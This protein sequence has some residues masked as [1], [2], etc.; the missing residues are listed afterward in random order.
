ML[1]KDAFVKGVFTPM[2]I[3]GERKSVH[4]IVYNIK[5]SVDKFITAGYFSRYFSHILKTESNNVAFLELVAHA[6][7]ECVQSIELR[8]CM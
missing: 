5:S 8:I 4:V 3:T 7:V 1:C 6:W 2:Y